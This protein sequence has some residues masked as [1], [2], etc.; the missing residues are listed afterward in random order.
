MNKLSAWSNKK[1]SLNQDNDLNDI[2]SGWL[3]RQIKRVRSKVLDIQALTSSTDEPQIIKNR[4]PA[5]FSRFLLSCPA[6][7]DSAIFSTPKQ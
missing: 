4:H 6:E 1:L 7:I 3:L 5:I 2:S